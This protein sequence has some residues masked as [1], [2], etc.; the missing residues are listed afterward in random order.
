MS[1]VQK[2][3]ETLVRFIYKSGAHVDYWTTK[4]LVKVS[5]APMGKGD[6]VV[7]IDMD[8]ADKGIKPLSFNLEAIES[9]HQIAYREVDED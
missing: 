9:V 4:C 2:R 5:K 1:E 8:M 7:G 6:I 3:I